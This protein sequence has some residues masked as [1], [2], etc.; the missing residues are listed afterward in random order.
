MTEIYLDNAATTRA[1]PEVIEAV[2]RTMGEDFG[3]ASSLHKRGL[4]AA[5]QITTATEAIT[6]LVGS[7]RWKV[8]FTSGGSES[9][10]WAVRGVVPRGK[11]ESIVTSTLE[12]SAVMES[13]LAATA[14][15]GLLTAISAGEVGV[16]D[17]GKIAEAVDKQTALVS[18]TH[19]A[20]ELGTI[21]PVAQT[22]RAVRAVSKSCRFHVDAVQALAQLETLEY[23]PEIEMVSISAH[24]IHGPQGIGALL[25]RPQVKPRPLIHGGDQQSGLRPGTFNLGG[26]VGFGTAARLLNDRRSKGVTM[27]SKLADQLSSGLLENIGGIHL[28]GSQSQR[29]PGILVCAVDGVQSEVLLHALE[30]RGVLAASS[31]ACHASRKEPSQALTEAGLKTSQGALRFSLSFDTTRA[32]IEGAIKATISAVEAVRKGQAG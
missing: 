25:L 29:A 21:Q 11:R 4:A 19:V 2:A 31:S 7:G 27:M 13:C 5:R 20:N 8:I 6:D 3:N 15:N 14:Q 24:K 26:I 17:P 16:V 1:W 32:E 30:M 18:L 22:A 9:D 10:T 28:L 12:H 23:P